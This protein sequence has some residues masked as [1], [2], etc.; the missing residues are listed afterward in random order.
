[1]PVN[2][3]TIHF[4]KLDKITFTSSNHKCES[5]KRGKYIQVQLDRHLRQCMTVKCQVIEANSLKSITTV[6]E[7]WRYKDIMI[8]FGL[9]LK[10]CHLISNISM[11]IFFLNYWSRCNTGIRQASV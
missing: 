2:N 3:I 10:D 4:S 8:A 1:M 5:L 11:L 9:Y 6:E 7:R